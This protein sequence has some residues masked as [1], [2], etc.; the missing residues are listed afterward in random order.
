[1]SLKHNSPNKVK[2][3]PIKKEKEEPIDDDLEI[4]KQFDLNL[5]FGPCFS[6]F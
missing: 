6:K 5:K 1:M 2:L 3:S 4:L